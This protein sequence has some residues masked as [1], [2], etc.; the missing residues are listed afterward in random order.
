MST[1]TRTR[2]QAPAPPGRRNRPKPANV[3]PTGYAV[4]L[5]AIWYGTTLA[6]VLA[7]AGLLL[8]PPNQ[9]GGTAAN[10]G[11]D[12]SS[13]SHGGAAQ[14]VAG[15]SSPTDIQV[16]A[17]HLGNLRVAVTAAITQNGSDAL[18]DA[19][20][21]ARTDMV[22]MPGA[23]TQGPLLMEAVP[24]RPGTYT[25]QTRV[26][27]PGDYEVT[28]ELHSPHHTTA[29]TTVLVGTLDQR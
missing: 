19:R 17:R 3:V 8:L 1:P 7:A 25:V 18:T 2:A 5:L 12:H 13:H 10:V 21:T 23:H 27:M 29:S 22:Q 20:P 28:V 4:S 16:S 6:A 14:G 26:A 24:D 9:P 11:H 15:S